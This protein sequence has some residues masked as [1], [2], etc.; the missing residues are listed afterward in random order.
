MGLS[1]ATW[2]GK[3]LGMG[4]VRGLTASQPRAEANIWQTIVLVLAFVLV[5]ARKVGPRSSV[6]PGE[7]EL[8][9][10]RSQIETS[11]WEESVICKT[12]IGSYS[13]SSSFDFFRRTMRGER[14]VLT[15]VKATN[16]ECKSEHGT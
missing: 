12:R 11:G 14:K 16:S 8:R 1:R 9:T 13:L 2:V 15:S 4:F 6:V 3:G 10:R 7:Y 5:V